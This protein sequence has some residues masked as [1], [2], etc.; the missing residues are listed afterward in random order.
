[1]TQLKN[2]KRNDKFYSSVEISSISWA[3]WVLTN[4]QNAQP[5]IEDKNQLAVLLFDAAVAAQSSKRLQSK[6]CSKGDEKQIFWK[7]L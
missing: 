1:M 2:N 7:N 5:F 4:A 3:F 6:I